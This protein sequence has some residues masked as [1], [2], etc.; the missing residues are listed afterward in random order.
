M[1]FVFRKKFVIF[2]VINYWQTVTLFNV[3]EQKTWTFNTSYY[4][5]IVT[6]TVFTHS[7]IYMYLIFRSGYARIII[8]QINFSYSD[9]HK[10]FVNYP[11][12]YIHVPWRTKLIKMYFY[13]RLASASAYNNLI[14]LIFPYISSASCITNNVQ[15]LYLQLLYCAKWKLN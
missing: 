9:W 8:M 2:I 1:C 10:H 11:V 5:E 14:Q 13:V 7:Y 12:G 6:S 3:R 4:N 15:M